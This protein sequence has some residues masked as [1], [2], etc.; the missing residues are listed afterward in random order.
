MAKAPDAHAESFSASEPTL[1][2]VPTKHPAMP[3]PAFDLDA[4]FILH[5]GNLAVIHEAQAML[6][7]AIH[8][9]ARAQFGYVEQVVAEGKAVLANQDLVRPAAA[10]ANAQITIERTVAVTK[11]VLSLATDAQRRVGELISRRARANLAE[12]KVVA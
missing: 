3:L 11:Q 2:L 4:Y 7:D 12:F 10:I 9:I 5:K 6:A 1:T 8:S